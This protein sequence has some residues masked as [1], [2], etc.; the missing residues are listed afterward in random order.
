MIINLFNFKCYKGAHTLILP[1]KGVILIHGES[2]SGKSTIFTAIEFC[3]YGIGRE[4]NSHNT[5]KCSVEINLENINLKIYRQKGPNLLKLNYNN[6]DYVD[7][8]A[9]PIID[10]VFGNET[11]YQYTNICHQREICPFLM[12]NNSEKIKVLENVAYGNHNIHSKKKLQEQI[13]SVEKMRNTLTTQIEIANNNY[14]EILSKL[15]AKNIKVE[16]VNDI[17]DTNKTS[18]DFETIDKQ[19]FELYIQQIRQDNEN[20]KQKM[21]QIQQDIKNTNIKLHLYKQ[22]QENLSTYNTILEDKVK[23]NITSVEQTLLE[24]N[25]IN[26]SNTINNLEMYKKNK[27]IY[28]ENIKQIKII[29]REIDN[30]ISKINNNEYMVKNKIV[31]KEGEELNIKDK[32]NSKELETSLNILKKYHSFFYNP[33]KFIECNENIM[34]P[35][36]INFGI[37]PNCSINFFKNIYKTHIDDFNNGLLVVCP[38]CEVELMYTYRGDLQ[39]IQSTNLLYNEKQTELFKLFIN[40]CKDHIEIITGYDDYTMTDLMNINMD[41]DNI[42]ILKMLYETI[43]VYNSKLKIYTSQN[44]VNNDENINNIECELKEL[45]TKKNLLQ[46]K[47]AEYAS[48]RNKI[49][50]Y[51]NEILNI[52]NWLNNV[53]NITSEDEY[54]Q[55]EEELKIYEDKYNQTNKTIDN[56]EWYFLYK[57]KKKIYDDLNETLMNNKTRY[58]NL[59]FFRNILLECEGELFEKSLLSL[60]Y[61]VN[62]ELE[63]LFKTSITISLQSEVKASVRTGIDINILYKEF[64]YKSHKNLSGGE[65]SRLGIGFLLALNKYVGAKF[66]ILDETLSCVGNDLRIDTIEALKT[67]SNDKLVIIVNHDCVTGVFDYVLEL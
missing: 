63:K 33:N 20:I 37:Q 51:N 21:L 41:V 62:N 17:K 47:Q 18:V 57:N 2:G 52:N 15:Q 34:L 12:G 36:I 16:D 50:F 9:Q 32:C 39:L 25:I 14:L 49:E 24:D 55:L 43:N 31:Y 22:K 42:V 1:D 26:I 6:Q 45:H 67:I 30:N 56:L 65:E 28:D 60:G 53:N 38:N 40:Y 4:V 48:I 7:D 54:N 11:I 44:I 64:Q 13:T 46:K 59:C 5:S 10:D 29:Q 23:N 35:F 58:E 19:D 61:M 27:N 3:L 8:L 66:L